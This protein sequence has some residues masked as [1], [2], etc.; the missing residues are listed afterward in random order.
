LVF[1]ADDLAHLQRIVPALEAAMKSLEDGYY[2]F[3][4]GDQEI[5]EFVPVSSFSPDNIMLCF[6]IVMAVS[7]GTLFGI[8]M[9]VASLLIEPI[10]V[11]ELIQY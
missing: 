9:F 1:R 10:S 5:I 8:I 6:L 11:A 4:D 3:Q 2:R 7:F